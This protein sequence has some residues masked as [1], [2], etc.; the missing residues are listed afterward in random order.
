MLMTMNVRKV[1]VLMIIRILMDNTSVRDILDL[2][3]IRKT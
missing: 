3:L 1:V 2:T